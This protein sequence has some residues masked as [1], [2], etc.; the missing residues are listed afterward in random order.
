MAKRSVAI[1]QAI[2]ATHQSRIKPPDRHVGSRVAD[3]NLHKHKAKTHPQNPR[4]FGGWMAKQSA[5]IRQTIHA[6]P[7]ITD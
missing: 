5:A 1:R 2:H 4:V 7:P 3:S 6:T